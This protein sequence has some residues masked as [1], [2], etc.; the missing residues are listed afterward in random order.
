MTDEAT[1]VTCGLRI[2]YAVAFERLAC[3]ERGIPMTITCKVCRG[4]IPE[5]EKVD[6]H[7]ALCAEVVR[8]SKADAIEIAWGIIANAHGGD[9]SKAT[10]EW[11]AAAERWR[12][13]HVTKKRSLV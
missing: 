4:A 8:M 13:Q 6:G 2:G 10:P 12:D 3:D 7:T 5:G 11:R 9:W 1:R